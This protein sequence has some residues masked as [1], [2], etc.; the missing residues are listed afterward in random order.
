M[1]SEKVYFLNIYTVNEVAEILKLSSYTI[2][3][4]LREGKLE[5][6]KFG[7]EWRIPERAIRHYLEDLDE[8]KKK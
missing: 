7:S 2:R 5:G 8:D 6:A 4:Y 1:S 3:K